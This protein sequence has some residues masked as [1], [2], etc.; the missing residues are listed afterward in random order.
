MVLQQYTIF[1]TESQI[2]GSSGKRKCTAT[3]LTIDTCSQQTCDVYGINKTGMELSVDT[4][5][6]TCAVFAGEEATLR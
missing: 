3:T 4:R 5:T 1:N 2:E 6:A